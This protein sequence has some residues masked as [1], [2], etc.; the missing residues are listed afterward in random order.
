MVDAVEMQFAMGVQMAAGDELHPGAGDEA[1]QAAARGGRGGQGVANLG[2]GWGNFRARVAGWK[3]ARP[4]NRGQILQ[5]FEWDF[6]LMPDWDYL[7]I[8]KIGW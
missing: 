2:Q 8:L 5:N 4:K 6:L 3:S 1:E 7:L